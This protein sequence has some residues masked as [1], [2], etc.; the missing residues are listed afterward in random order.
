MTKLE[1]LGLVCEAVAFLGLLP[2]FVILPFF[3]G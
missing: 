3:I 1:R 2:A